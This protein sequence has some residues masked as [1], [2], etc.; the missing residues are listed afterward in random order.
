MSAFKM[1]QH[2][3]SPGQL[4]STPQST[5]CDSRFRQVREQAGHLSVSFDSRQISEA[6]MLLHWMVEWSACGTR[7]SPGL[8]RSRILGSMTV[9]QEG[10][11]IKLVDF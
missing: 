1:V 3:K 2:M 11:S 6:L 9:H 7:I 5:Q 8:T 4:I 10:K